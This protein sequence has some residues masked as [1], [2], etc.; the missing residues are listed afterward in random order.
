MHDPLPHVAAEVKDEVSDRV[1]VR[2]AALPDLLVAEPVH[3]AGYVACHQLQ[4][5]AR[6]GKK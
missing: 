3:A 6:C 4:L 2:S 5:R 1:L